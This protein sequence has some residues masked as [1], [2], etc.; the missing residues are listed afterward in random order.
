MSEALPPPLRL[1]VWLD[2]LLR[3]RVR[4]QSLRGVPWRTFAA[5]TERSLVR[6]HPWR[7]RIG[8]RGRLLLAVYDLGRRDARAELEAR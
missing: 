3:L 1:R 5:L 6:G 7:A 4:P 2:I 8:H